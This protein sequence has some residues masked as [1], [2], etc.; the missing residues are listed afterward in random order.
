[1]KTINLTDTAKMIRTALVARFGKET[2]FSV[3][4]KNYSGGCSITV[5]WTD[6][7]TAKEVD[8]VLGNFEGASFDGMQDMKTHITQ[9]LDGEVVSYAADYVFSNRS[10][11]KE[12][13]DKVKGLL[14]EMYPQILR[15]GYFGDYCWYP[16]KGAWTSGIDWD[17]TYRH[18]VHSFDATTGQFIYTDLLNGYTVDNWQYHENEVEA[19]PE[20]EIV[21]TPEPVVAPEPV[22]IV[23]VA[24]AKPKRD[25]FVNAKFA[26][27]NKRSS[28]AEYQAEVFKGDKFYT[29]QR[30]RIVKIAYLSATD[31]DRY[32]E[33]LMEPQPWL[34]GEGGH[35][36]TADVPDVDSFWQLSPEHQKAWRDAAYTLTVAV[37]APDRP[38]LYAN[39]EG[40]N[41]S[42]YLGI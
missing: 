29:E 30:C 17:R 13:D 8:L 12:V 32:A 28:L 9:E 35:E 26:K 23:P 38:T 39:P 5:S 40:S 37:T 14:A 22:V 11:S 18:A 20:P 25:T 31:W 15:E 2:K 42:R 6:G 36:S 27:L 1:M 34:N 16:T 3:R 19:Q 41:Y 21:A 33:N 10:I 24:I 7:P 4:S